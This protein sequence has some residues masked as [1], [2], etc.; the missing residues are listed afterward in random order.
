ILRLK[1]LGLGF[2]PVMLAYTLYNASY[3]V[4]SYPAG[5]VADRRPKHL[6][7]AAGL[8]VFAVAY[9]GFGLATSALWAWPLLVI[10]GGYTALTDGVGKAWIASLVPETSVGAALGYYQG[11][12]GIAS[13]AAGLWAGLL[14]G[15]GGT[16]PFM[17]SGIVAGV[18][19]LVL[20]RF[21]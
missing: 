7:F 12:S 16:V 4:L 3:A 17:I 19:A 10:Y 6:V 11:A 14:W 9:L 15:T 5:A 18:V 2:V 20:M 1:Q 13:V 21:D 8:G